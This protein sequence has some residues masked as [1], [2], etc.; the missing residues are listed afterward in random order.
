[1]LRKQ[2]LTLV[3]R[4]RFTLQNFLFDCAFLLLKSNIYKEAG[5]I[6]FMETLEKT[7]EEV[8]P[9]KEEARPYPTTEKPLYEG[10]QKIEDKVYAGPTS[11][12]YWM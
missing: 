4:F 6:K 11:I 2:S 5:Y 12:K 3:K 7:L 9:K 1:L 8:A 10:L